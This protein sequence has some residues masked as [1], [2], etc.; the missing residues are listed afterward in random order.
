M[1]IAQDFRA[2]GIQVS[3]V[4]ISRRVRE[5]RGKTPRKR[6]LPRGA[7]A[8]APSPP[9]PPAAPPSDPPDDP[10]P[11][12]DYS[13]DSTI[14]EI[15]THLE[16]A[17]E[18]AAAAAA[19]GNADEHATYM[20]MIVQLLEARR[21]AAPAPKIDPNENPDMIA[22]AAR[23]RKMFYALAENLVR[24]ASSPVAVTIQKL[25]ADR[26]AEEEA[27]QAEEEKKKK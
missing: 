23:A 18:K 25:L 16:V 10:A 8:A 24:V 9:S 2:R 1:T 27:K 22:E 12:P 11:A 5:L 19:I 26:R 21:K 15:D 20:R 7:S 4:T 13:A 3:P 14:R 17:K 6:P